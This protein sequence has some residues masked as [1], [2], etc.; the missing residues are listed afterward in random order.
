M[1]HCKKVEQRFNVSQICSSKEEIMDRVARIGS[2][3]PKP[4]AIYLAV[5]DSLLEDDSIL[6]GWK[7]GL[8]PFEK[9]KLGVW[10]VYQKYPYIIQAAMDFEVCLRADVFVGNS[11]ST[12][13]SLV[14]LQRTQNWIKT[15]SGSSC[16]ANLSFVSYAYNILGGNGGAQRWMVDM[17]ASSL[18]S[19]SYGTNNISCEI[20]KPS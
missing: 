13:S 17:S 8:I 20:G 1:I 6:S 3:L 10:D 2:D 11:Y 15:C 14:V 9:K 12:F 18:R 19:I 7:Q 5:A 16:G 4:I